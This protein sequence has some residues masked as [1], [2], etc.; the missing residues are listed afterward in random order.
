MRDFYYSDAWKEYRNKFVS[1]VR[2]LLQKSRQ[3]WIRCNLIWASIS[4]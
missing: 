1:K 4:L 2:I 3:F